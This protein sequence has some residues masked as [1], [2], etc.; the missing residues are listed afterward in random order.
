MGK[1]DHIA[2]CLGFG[3]QHKT[4]LI[5]GG[6]DQFNDVKYDDMWLL[7]LQ[8]GKMEKVRRTLGNKYYVFTFSGSYV[9]NNGINNVL[10]AV[11]QLP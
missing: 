5:S 2:A 9:V 1:C 4:V 8:S 7:D 11:S 10:L 6:S 3:G